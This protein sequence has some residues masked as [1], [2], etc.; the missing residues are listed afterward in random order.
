MTRPVGGFSVV[1]SL[2][3]LLLIPLLAIAAPVPKQTEREKIEAKFGKIVDPKGDSKFELDG[4]ALKI[5]LP[6]GEERH[7]G[8]TADPAD[9]ENI[10]KYKKFDDNP[11]VEFTRTGDF[12]LTVRV[13][14]PLAEDT[15]GTRLGGGVRVT[16]KD[17]NWYR[18]GVRQ[19]G[20]LKADRTW[21]PLDW[22]NTFSN[23]GGV[24]VEGF[25]SS[26]VWIRITHRGKDL[27]R[28]YGKDGKKWVTLNEH[29][30]RISDDTL[31]LAL[32]G[33]H[34]AKKAQTVTLDQFSVEKPDAEKK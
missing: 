6:A 14:M 29:T 25:D 30:D 33:E 24:T 11:R 16:P 26:V 3:A 7:F 34:M 20:G 23:G 5:T 31:A 4:E 19:D 12:V 27:T 28:D 21:F 2:I 10:K 15:V 9:R 18:F 22:P 17:G 1:R 8:F 32:Y 13:S